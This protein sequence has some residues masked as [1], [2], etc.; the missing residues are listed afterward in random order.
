MPTYLIYLLF[1]LTLTNTVSAQIQ[2]KIDTLQLE[3]VVTD[4]VQI[5]FKG[6]PY[7]QSEIINNS[8]SNLLLHSAL[9][10]NKNEHQLSKQDL[11]NVLIGLEQELITSIGNISLNLKKRKK[12]ISSNAYYNS[13]LVKQL[14]DQY[15][16]ITI[17]K[18]KTAIIDVRKLQF[19]QETR[20]KNSRVVWGFNPEKFF[21]KISLGKYSGKTLYDIYRHADEE[22][23]Q[24]GVT[25]FLE[26]L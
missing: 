3:T 1:V 9:N 25:N 18:N 12:K 15:S 4:S 2:V 11:D 10:I 16:V 20:I 17:D 5:I 19:K 13:E 26:Q 6:I 7:D 22:N 14:V 21:I 23:I 8:L 24:E